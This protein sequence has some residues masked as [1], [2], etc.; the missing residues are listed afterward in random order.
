MAAESLVSVN[1]LTGS[2][3]T[4]IFPVE[5]TSK[6]QLLCHSHD[7]LFSFISQE[8]TIKPYPGFNAAADAKTLRA[9]M[10]GY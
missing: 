3:F 9:A 2:F 8:P 1:S 7:F 4:T 5:D 6:F 10:K